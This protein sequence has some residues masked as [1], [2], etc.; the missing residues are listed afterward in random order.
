VELDINT[1]FT[2]FVASAT[3]VLGWYVRGM[4][5]SI[6]ALHSADQELTKEVNKLNVLV[7]GDYLR[8]AEFQG[9]MTE[10]KNMIG[11]LSRAVHTGFE[12]LHEKVNSKADR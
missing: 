11:E 5:E 10:M 8:R 6:D 3:A 2:A 9:D 12:R 1:L 7:V 4:R